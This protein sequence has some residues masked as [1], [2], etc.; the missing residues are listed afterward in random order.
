MFAD[1]LGY[2]IEPPGIDVSGVQTLGYPLHI[3][4]VNTNPSYT[5]SPNTG[6]VISK[7]KIT[8]KGTYDDTALTGDE[9]HNVSMTLD[10]YTY[11]DEIS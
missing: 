6:I 1:I 5:E 11:V 7:L 10:K 4:V 8:L 2:T 3:Y 9:T